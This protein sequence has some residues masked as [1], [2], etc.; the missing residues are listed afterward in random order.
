MSPAMLRQ[1]GA[2]GSSRTQFFRVTL[3][4]TAGYFELPSYLNG[5]KAGPLLPDGPKSQECGNACF[6]QGIDEIDS[7]YE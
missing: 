2:Y 4:T 3:D 7:K 6:A 1:V 5:Q